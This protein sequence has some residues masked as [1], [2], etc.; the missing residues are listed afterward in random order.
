MNPYG[1]DLIVDQ[2]IG[3]AYQ[4]VKYVAANM[5]TLIELSDAMDTIQSVLGQLQDLINNLPQL[6]ELQENLDELL[7]IHSHLS[8]LLN[9]SSHMAELLS[10][11][12]ALDE[13]LT[14]YENLPAIV[15][16]SVSVSTSREAIVRSYNEAGYPMDKTESFELG[17]TITTTKETLLYEQNGVGYSWGG[18]LPKVVPANSTPSTTG[19]IGPSAWVDQSAKLLRHQLTT[20]SGNLTPNP[21]WTDVPSNSDPD[22]GGPDGPLNMQAKAL[23][24]RSE[25]L[26]INV[27]EALQRSLAEAGYTLVAGSFETGGSVSLVSDALLYE[28][29]GIAYS[30]CG[31]LTK[32]VPPDST[33]SSTGGMSPT[34]WDN[35]AVKIN[36]NPDRHAAVMQAM[37]DGLPVKI[38]VVGDSITNGISVS[39]PFPYR[40]GEILR[41]WYRNPNITIIKR[42][43][44]GHDTGEVL[45]QHLPE[46][47]ADNADLYLIALGVNDARQDRDISVDMYEEDL[48]VMYHRLSFAAVSFCSL[49]DVVGLQPTDVTNPYAIDAYRS[50]MK[51]VAQTCGARYIDSYSFMQRYMFNRGDAR[52]RLS[53]DRLHW[54]QA[55]YD[56][57]AESIFCSGFA[58]TNLE[59]G[60]NQFIDNTTSA[61][62][63]ANNVLNTLNCPYSVF[64]R[65]PEAS[66]SKLYIFNTSLKPAYLLAH[67][68]SQLTED[69][70]VTGQV[71]VKNSIEPT[72]RTYTL[73][74]ANATGIPSNFLSDVPTSVCDLAPGL[75]II[76]FTTPVD[77]ILRVVGFTVKE[78]P[79]SHNV[80]MREK[81]KIGSKIALGMLDQAGVVDNTKF[82]YEI[83]FRRTGSNQ[84]TGTE[85]TTDHRLPRSLCTLIPKVYGETRF[86]IRGCFGTNSVLSL[87]YQIKS[88]D[89]AN[90]WS[91]NCTQLFALDFQ[92]STTYMRVTSFTGTPISVAS[93]SNARGDQC[94]DIVTSE[95]GTQFYLQGVLLWSMAIK[96]PEVD[97]FVSSAYNSLAEG[98]VIE[99]VA[100]VGTA[101]VP[102]T[103]VPGEKWF[104]HMDSKMHVVDKSGVHKTVLYS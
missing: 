29:E 68:T 37:V 14:V 85:G 18:A 39:N 17:G 12:G 83:P 77:K 31:G 35:L 76:T 81:A 41:E 13:I 52:G 19:G 84:S 53:R 56:L 47:I 70:V 92:G 87:G 61:Y 98:V 88:T 46:I 90:E 72:S 43:Y 64:V 54:N 33:P 96:L 26:R 59:V 11:S 63:G 25:L 10:V 6:L 94:I 49:T 3:S 79:D 45:A 34:A 97:L 55:G 91:A 32:T 103:F 62:R 40:L 100:E 66:E 16:A 67:F 36:N 69:G 65:T 1:D 22:L 23:V 102:N 93:I 101:V 7:L 4:V 38:C 78:Y 20:F 24:G 9:I 58:G 74:I 42:G 99:S 86:R 21:E 75:N 30:W 28:K 80:M 50:R 104:S 2:V 60:P 8:E 89:E 51:H 82:Y 15:D 95:A 27:R 44:S 57:I 73:D 48:R 5:S 71:T